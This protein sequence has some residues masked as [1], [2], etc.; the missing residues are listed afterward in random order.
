MR[1]IL[2]SKTLATFSSFLDSISVH[3]LRGTFVL[4][5]M[6]LQQLYG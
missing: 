6:P 2:L 3:P 4:L 1:S 5:A